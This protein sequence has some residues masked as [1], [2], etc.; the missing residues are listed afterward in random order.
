MRVN[1]SKNSFTLSFSSPKVSQAGY[2]IHVI[3]YRYHKEFLC[4]GHR[5]G[6]ILERDLPTFDLFYLIIMNM[7]RFDPPKTGNRSELLELSFTYACFYLHL[8]V[9]SQSCSRWSMAHFHPFESNRLQ[10]FEIEVQLHDSARSR[11]SNLQSYWTLPQKLRFLLP[12][13]CYVS[14]PMFFLEIFGADA[15][16]ASCSI[17]S[18]INSDPALNGQIWIWSTTHY[19]TTRRPLLNL[20]ITNA[21]GFLSSNTAGTNCDDDE[22]E[23]INS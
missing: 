20:C 11:V 2:V 10:V 22:Y 17:T 15:W 12:M 1:S 3:R 23:Y 4:V 6:C 9:K 19:T 14:L 5:M 7:K 8:Q 16:A 13:P 18:R 21:E